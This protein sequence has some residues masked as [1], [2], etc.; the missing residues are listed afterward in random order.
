M[1]NSIPDKVLNHQSN[2]FVGRFNCKCLNLSN[3]FMFSTLETKEASESV[4]CDSMAPPFN[5][6]L[7]RNTWP[8]VVI[9]FLFPHGS[10]LPHRSTLF[11]TS[12]ALW[13]TNAAC[14]IFSCLSFFLISTFYMLE[15][16]NILFLIFAQN[17]KLKFWPTV[18]T[19]YQM[20]CLHIGFMFVNTVVLQIK[21]AWPWEGMDSGST[22]PNEEL[23]AVDGCWERKS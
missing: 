15:D 4:R 21:P 8:R 3:E 16:I 10:Q 14:F 9:C 23:L 6:R 17:F 11:F 2:E 7:N 20:S 12:W 5:F 22:T 13:R 18:C 1:A 19:Q